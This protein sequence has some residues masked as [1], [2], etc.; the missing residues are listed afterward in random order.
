VVSV[1]SIEGLVYHELRTTVVEEVKGNGKKKKGTSPKL[2]M[3]KEIQEMIEAAEVFRT[4]NNDIPEALTL[5]DSILVRV[6]T[7][8][9]CFD[10]CFYFLLPSFCSL[11]GNSNGGGPFIFLP[12][13]DQ[14]GGFESQGSLSQTAE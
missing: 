3:K 12:G 4:Y 13:S 10:D 1:G 14:P 8:F 5:L 6:L 7:R 11:S 9:L 2:T